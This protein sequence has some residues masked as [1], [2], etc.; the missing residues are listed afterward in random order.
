MKKCKCSCGDPHIEESEI[1]N[2]L[3]EIKNT[4]T[5][6]TR[7]ILAESFYRHS[8]DDLILTVSKKSKNRLDKLGEWRCMS[9]AAP[10]PSIIFVP[11]FD[12]K[13]GYRG[14]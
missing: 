1:K 6:Q 2:K 9:V 12:Y 5:G 4:K 7:R 10:F 13:Y 3:Y 8:E 11:V 14:E